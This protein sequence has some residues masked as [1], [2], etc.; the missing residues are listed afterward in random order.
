M[1]AIITKETKLAL[2]SNCPRVPL[3]YLV[4]KVHKDLKQPPGLP[5]VSVVNSI[6]QPIA[7]YVD[8]FLQK[9]VKKLPNCLK[10]TADFLH[11]IEGIDVQ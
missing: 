10:D 9:I 11:R 3:L 2:T 1:T 5:I 8:G 7:I 6:F 4:P